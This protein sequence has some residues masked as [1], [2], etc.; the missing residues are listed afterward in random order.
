M[1]AGE[2]AVQDNLRTTFIT[3]AAKDNGWLVARTGRYG[4]NYMARALV[5]KIGLGAPVSKLAIYPFTITDRNL[6]PLTGA[7]RYVA[8]FSAQN[9]PFPVRSFWSLTM[10]DSNGFFVANSAHVY[11]INNRSHVQYNSDGSLDL[12]I[13]PSAPSDPLQRRNWLP[14]PGGQAF[15]LIMRLYK[16]VDIPGILSGTSWRPPTILPC[17]ANGMTADGVACAR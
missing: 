12:Y 10:Y 17:L 6:T 13:Q 4:T 3:G 7:K 15:R 2:R 8:H 9:L 14:S 1:A 11:L 16:P 5:D